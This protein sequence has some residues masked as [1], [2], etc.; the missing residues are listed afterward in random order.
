VPGTWRN[1]SAASKTSPIPP[2]AN[3]DTDAVERFQTLTP[4]P[5][6]FP[7]GLTVLKA[8]VVG[9]WLAW[10]WMAGIVLFSNS[11]NVRH[12]V[13]AWVA[14]GVAF[15]V[16]AASTAI[17]RSDP[18]KLLHIAFVLTEVGLA[19]GLSMVDGYVFEP[20]HVFATTQSIATQWPLLA[21]ATAGVAFGPVIAGLLGILVGPAELGGAILNDHDSFGTPE[22][23]SI[24]ATSLFYG[25]CGGVF[26]WQARLLK[27]VEGEIADRRARDEVRRVLHDTVLQTLAL[28]TRR[29]S[30]SDPE[31]ATAARDADRDL[32]AFLFG[33]AGLT[34]DSAADRIRSGVERVRRGHQTPV[35]V[36]VI[37][38]GCRLTDDQQNLLARAIGEAT[39][40]A[41]EHANATKIVVFAETD[42][43]GQMFA[44]VH[45]DGDGF[46]P[47]APRHSQGLD[48]SVIARIESIGGKVTI[49]SSVGSGT[50]IK[51]WTRRPS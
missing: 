3:C 18:E 14:V 21:A 40:N 28:V 34:T 20:G 36:N 5:V 35:T 33:S 50:E 13:L 9:R 27:R 41:L 43:R 47:T 1:A 7:T 32:R 49:T 31:L 19:V 25:A 17:I 45:D 11:D 23:V 38:D 44:T 39:A 16:T 6:L 29:T 42:E 10:A 24:A 22:I 4:R 8:L 26:G 2:I 46:D 51:L 12:P 30:D 37:D 48:E 15:A